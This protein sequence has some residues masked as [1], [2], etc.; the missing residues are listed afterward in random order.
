M[1]AMAEHKMLNEVRRMR[2]E[3]ASPRDIA[4]TLGVRPSVVAPLVRQAA[5]ERPVP[6]TSEAEVVGCWVSPGWT[7][8]LLVVR[9]EGWDDVDLGPDGPKGIALVLVA[10]AERHDGVSVCG[11]LVDTFCLGVKNVIGPE[12]MR[13]RGLPSFVRTYFM[14]F[15]APAVPAPIDLAQHVV[16]GAVSY[17]ETLGFSPHPEFE[18]ARCHLGQLSEQCAISFGRNGHPLYV[19]GLDDDPVTVINTLNATLGAGRFAVAA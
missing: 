6:V 3:G 2:A 11:Y 15:P 10:R 16:L 9:R 7:S 4:R 8:D 5:A 14:A 17:A 12:R 1:S 19:A 13:R 18:R